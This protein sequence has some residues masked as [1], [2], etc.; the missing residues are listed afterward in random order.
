MR[1]VPI[2]HKQ[3]GAQG[4]TRVDPKPWGKLNARWEHSAGWRLFHCGHPTAHWPWALYDPRGRQ[5]CMGLAVSGSRPTFG[6]AFDSLCRAATYV[7]NMGRRAIAAMDH[8][9]R[10]RPSDVR[11]LDPR[12][13]TTPLPATFS[14]PRRRQ[15]PPTG[16]P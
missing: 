5:H 9:E 2:S 15:R 11:W 14:P 13:P 3:M 6:C 1:D 4:W 12:G 10:E 8:E 7:T 16:A